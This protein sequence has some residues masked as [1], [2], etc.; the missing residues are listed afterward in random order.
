[1]RRAWSIC[2]LRFGDADEI[3][4]VAQ[5]GFIFFGSSVR[6][7]RQ[8]RSESFALRHD[9]AGFCG[10]E[11]RGNPR[12]DPRSYVSALGARREIFRTAAGRD[13]GRFALGSVSLRQRTDPIRQADHFLS[14]VSNAWAQT[15]PAARSNGVLLVLDFEKN[16][17][18]PGGT[19]RVDQAIAF[20]QR[21]HERTGKY[22]G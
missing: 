6:L 1:M 9:A 19:M 3:V 11:E 14:V 4:D 13:T 18:Y 8:Q 2:P 5:R 20:V 21:I 15:D 17:H 12:C 22:P 10:D 16:G 7:C